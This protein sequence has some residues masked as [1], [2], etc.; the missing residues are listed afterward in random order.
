VRPRYVGAGRGASSGRAGARGQR[1]S[2]RA[3]HSH[4]AIDLPWVEVL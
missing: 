2:E 1:V 4:L 3:L